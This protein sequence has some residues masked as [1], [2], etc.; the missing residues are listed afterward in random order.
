M[1]SINC[2][3]VR[4]LIETSDNL[5]KDNDTV[6]IEPRANW[7]RLP[8]QFVILP[9]SYSIITSICSKK[10]G[11]YSC[12]FPQVLLLFPS[13]YFFLFYLILAQ[14]NQLTQYHP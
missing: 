4:S 8:A 11:V 12:M 7:G 2:L 14:M 6:T 3:V 10:V 1:F 5:Q 9:Q 13:P